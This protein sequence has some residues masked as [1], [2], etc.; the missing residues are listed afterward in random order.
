MIS[1]D[2]DK[3]KK[4]LVTVDEEGNEIVE[5]EAISKEDKTE[6]LSALKAYGFGEIV[7]KK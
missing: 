2:I 4:R 1:I 6:L 3:L 5:R 7:N